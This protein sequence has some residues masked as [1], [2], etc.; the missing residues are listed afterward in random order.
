VFPIELLQP[1]LQLSIILIEHLVLVFFLR[2]STR[3]EAHSSV[4]LVK[5]QCT[6]L[7]GGL[8]VLNTR[9]C[10]MP[11]LLHLLKGWFFPSLA[12]ALVQLFVEVGIHVPESAHALLLLIKILLE[13]SVVLL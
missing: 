5:L 12:Q 3:T 13:F 6:C 10:M 1:L 2:K 11:V 9:L 7:E 4:K 8:Q